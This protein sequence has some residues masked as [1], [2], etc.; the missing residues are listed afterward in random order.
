MGRTH[1]TPIQQPDSATCGPASIKHALEIFGVRKSLNSLI[2]L[3]KTTRNGTTTRHMIAALNKLGFWVLAVEYATLRHIQSALKCTPGKMRAGI[4]SYLY[5]LDK[6]RRPHPDSGHWAVV[7]SYSARN[8]RIVL[9]D[10]SKAQKTSYRWIN[11]LPR[12]R[13]YDLKRKKLS[14]RSKKFRL[15]RHWQNQLLLVVARESEHLP[16]FRTETGRIFP[17]KS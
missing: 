3:C 12:W 1:V 10:S 5:D 8:G 9:F 6:K 2:E 11:F 17:P 16:K 14:K 15:I 13:D 7:G 4:L